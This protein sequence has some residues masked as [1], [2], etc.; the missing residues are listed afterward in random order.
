[1]L[2]EHRWSGRWGASFLALVLLASVLIAGSAFSASRHQHPGRASQVSH[3]RIGHVRCDPAQQRAERKAQR[4]AERRAQ[5]KADRRAERKQQR[6]KQAKHHRK[7]G[8]QRQQTRGRNAAPSLWSACAK[9][10]VRN[11]RDET[12]PTIAI[13]TPKAGSTVDGT[14][15]VSGVAGDDVMLRSIH[16]QLDD[17]TP[18]SVTPGLTWS[19]DLATGRLASGP[20]QI[21]AF[22][23]DKG[24]NTTYATLEVIVANRG[25][26]PVP[27]PSPAPDPAPSPA[28]DPSPAPT[29]APEPGQLPGP[30]PTG[31]ARG[32]F[33]VSCDLTHQA[34]DDPIVLPGKPGAAHIHDFF[35]ALDV[36]AFT[37]P[38]TMQKTSTCAH[39]GDMAAYWAPALVAPDGAVVK[40]T[41]VLAYYRATAAGPVRAAPQGLEIVAGGVDPDLFGY[42]CSDQGPYSQTPVDCPQKLVLHIVFPNCWDGVRLD[43]AD[44]RSHMA[45]PGKGGQ[46]PA[47]HP[48]RIVQL[49]MH[50]QYPKLTKGS[51]YHLA[52]NSDGTLPGPHADFVNGWDQTVLEHI[53]RDCLNP[54]LNCKLDTTIGL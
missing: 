5:R 45:Y 19:I 46:C 10:A 54:G 3:Q 17:R 39:P 52:P 27:A 34:K 33:S 49:S 16:V 24:L 48:V 15:T 23:R 8:Q 43:S 25:S 13:T 44:H 40:P 47:D 21:L 20:H 42:S 6:S 18:R 26:G 50:V 4:R 22:A 12:F 2:P 37:T 32:V 31:P 53:V 38:S 14:I 11:S 29:P 9:Q 35:G 7:Q 41:R 36:D 51:A 1:M 28:P 30:E